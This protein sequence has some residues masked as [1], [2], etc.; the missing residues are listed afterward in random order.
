MVDDVEAVD[1]WEFSQNFDYIH[2]RLLI[3]SMRDWPRYFRRCFANLKPGG[4]V[5][6]QEVEMPFRRDEGAPGPDSPIIEWSQCVQQGSSKVGI[7]TQASHRFADLLRDEG[8][9][10]ITKEEYRWAI[11]PWS[12]DRKEREVGK[13]MTYNALEGVESAGMALFSRVFG[14]SKAEIEKF[15]ESVKKDILN[16]NQRNYSPM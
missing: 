9:V 2:S 4:W 7:D 3:L 8:F 10:N 1:D 15:L 6:V 5:E 11:G 14:W 16:P 12:S 13:W